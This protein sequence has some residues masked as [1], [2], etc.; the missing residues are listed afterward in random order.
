MDVK[1]T[2]DEVVAFIKLKEMLKGAATPVPQ[3]L[4]WVADRLVLVYKD[5]E[6]VDF[7][8]ALRHRAKQL[9]EITILLGVDRGCERLP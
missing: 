5:N 6:Q 7:V 8:Q 4:H 9:H 3:F 1:L 2:D